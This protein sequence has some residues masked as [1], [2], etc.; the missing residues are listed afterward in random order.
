MLW[1]VALLPCAAFAQPRMTIHD[2]VVASDSDDQ[3]LT[4]TVAEELPARLGAG[5]IVLRNWRLEVEALEVVG[6]WLGS[7]VSVR[8]ERCVIAGSLTFGS[9]AAPQLSLA[10]VEQRAGHAPA[11]VFLAPRLS[12]DQTAAY[13]AGAL[14]V[15]DSRFEAPRSVGGSHGDVG[16]VYYARGLTFTG[17]TFEGRQT[18]GLHFAVVAGG[19]TIS[20]N[21]VSSGATLTLNLEDTWLPEITSEDLAYSPLQI[22]LERTH[23]GGAADFSKTELVDSFLCE[24]CVFDGTF[25]A[26]SRR[27]PPTRFFHTIFN[28]DV[29]LTAAEFSGVEFEVSEFKGDVHLMATR[30]ARALFSYCVFRSSL[31]LTFAAFDEAVDFSGSQMG[32]KSSF[33][34][35]RVGG[36]ILFNGVDWPADAQADFSGM[37]NAGPLTGLPWH[38][39]HE[40]L[41]RAYPEEASDVL[42]EIN[43]AEERRQDYLEQL[44]RATGGADTV[45][46]EEALTRA[47]DSPRHDPADQV[48]TRRTARISALTFLEKGY[49]AAGLRSDELAAYLER[50]RAERRNKSAFARLTEAVFVDAT[51]AYGTRPGLVLLWGSLW[52][53]TCGLIYAAWHVQPT[54]A[55]PESVIAPAALWPGARLTRPVQLTWRLWYGLAFSVATFFS[56]D[57]EGWSATRVVRPR[58]TF[59][60]RRPFARIEMR[61]GSGALFQAVAIAET[62]AAWI[63]LALLAATLAKVWID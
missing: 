26:P 34:M 18:I 46:N 53:V 37:Q 43:L 41:R 30:H 2:N 54:D 63:L 61:A 14:A 1:T 17:N 39:A 9:S 49:R 21:V 10:E 28:G 4:A 6:R 38:R 27:F 45:V 16:P 25:S 7:G 29:D 50:K 33:S 23:I 47:L 57:M 3:V 42:A 48:R 22:E 40:L 32:S 12:A 59:T 35:V 44:A 60:R 31:D 5:P 55:V 15:R 56:K 58:L 11:L 20:R 62:A 36:A 24:S 52:I 19:L 13:V 8:L 51:C